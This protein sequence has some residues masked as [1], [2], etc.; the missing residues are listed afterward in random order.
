M[1]SILRDKADLLGIYDADLFTTSQLQKEVE[2]VSRTQ[3]ARREY[4]ARQY[5]R[6]VDTKHPPTP[7]GVVD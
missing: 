1:N 7:S 2:Y 3:K 4:A 6:V 5:S